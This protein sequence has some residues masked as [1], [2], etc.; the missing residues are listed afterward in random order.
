MN[1]EFSDIFDEIEKILQI[2]ELNLPFS[3][4]VPEGGGINKSLEKLI[5]RSKNRE[6]LFFDAMQA[7]NSKRNK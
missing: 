4:G 5:D 2:E 6:D 1:D 3:K 7:I